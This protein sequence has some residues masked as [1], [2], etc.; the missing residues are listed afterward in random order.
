M[1]T[2]IIGA[3]AIGGLI[4]IRLAQAGCDVSVLA[5]GATADALRTGPWRLA[6]AD[7]EVTGSVR[8]ADDLMALG[9]Q[10][11]VVIAVKGQSLPGLAPSLAPL[12]GTETMVLPAMNGVPWWFFRR[13]GGPL[14]GMPLDSV[15]PGR[16]IAAAIADEAVVGCVVH[17]TCSV[18]EPGLVRHGFGNRLIVG[19]PDGSLSPRL[20]RLWDCLTAAGFEVQSSPRI[21]T[22]IW[23]KLWGNM[24]M[25][26]V[27]AL[28]GATCDRILDDPLVSGFCLSVMAEAAELGRLIGCPIEQSG[29]DRNAV[30]R[31]LG[32]FKT[33]MLQ[34]AEAGKPLEIDA[35]L[36]A[37]KEIAGRLGQATPNLDALL[38]LTRL[39]AGTRG[40][41]PSMD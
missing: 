7:G 38:G 36:G 1:K 31:R 37:V 8:V 33:S 41:Y 15:D 4:G 23:Y 5:R 11:L 35:L 21:Q 40:L 29:E 9:P 12:I 2:C 18:A 39:M 32:A 20:G 26:P 28:T 30:T 25:N 24:T 6:T 34:D 13:F 27:S 17:A 22:D 16:R 19:E 14:A 3:G 10:D